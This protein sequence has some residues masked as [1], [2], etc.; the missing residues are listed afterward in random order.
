MIHIAARA[1]IEFLPRR[2]GVLGLVDERAHAF[3]LLDLVPEVERGR[4]ALDVEQRPLT[5]ARPAQG[6]EHGCH[7]QNANPPS[8]F[9]R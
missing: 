5:M 7:G 2:G 3:L 8:R 9:V 6:K 1:D 4:R